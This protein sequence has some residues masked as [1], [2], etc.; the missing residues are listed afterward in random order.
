MSATLENSLKTEMAII[1]N[2]G[3]IL[4]RVEDMERRV[5]SLTQVIKELKG[6]VKTLKMEQRELAYEMEDQENRSRR[7]KT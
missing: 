4:I 5:D 2:L 3:H 7:K 1:S 6:E